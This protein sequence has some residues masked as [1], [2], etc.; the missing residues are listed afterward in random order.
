MF[1]FKSAFT[2]NPVESKNRKL[3][4]SFGCKKIKQNLWQSFLSSHC[5]CEEISGQFVAVTD[6]MFNVSYFS[7][8]ARKWKDIC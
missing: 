1:G 6:I 3:K 7:C 5:T 4:L 2:C 8:T